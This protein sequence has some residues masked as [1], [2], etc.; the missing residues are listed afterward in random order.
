MP[1]DILLDYDDTKFTNE[2]LQQQNSMRPRIK[3]NRDIQICP[4]IKR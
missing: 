3:R 1:H 2:N 4:S